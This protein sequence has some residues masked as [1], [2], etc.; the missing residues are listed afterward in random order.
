MAEGTGHGDT[1]T[2]EV[3]LKQVYGV[4]S[5]EFDIPYDASALDFL[6]FTRGTA[7][8]Q[9]GQAPLYIVGTNS[10]GI[11]TVAVNLLGPGSVDVTGTHVLVGLTFRARDSGT[12]QIAFQAPVLRDDNFQTI[13]V[14]WHSGTLRA[15]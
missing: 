2:V 13:P 8:E 4:R 10:P 12:F 7:L 14:A 11:L 5:A 3:R 1:L 15:D 6:G 9:S